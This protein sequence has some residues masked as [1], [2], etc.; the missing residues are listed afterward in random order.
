MLRKTVIILFTATLFIMGCAPPEPI[1]IYLIGD[2]IT[3]TKP[4]DE[5]PMVGWGQILPGYFDS[6][7]VNIHNHAKN[8]RSTKSF[9]SEGRW[10]TVKDS[11]QPG[12]WVLIQFGHNDEKEYDTTRYTDPDS[13]FPENLKKFVREARDLG[14]TPLLMTPVVRRKF[15]DSGEPVPTHGEYPAAVQGVAEKL[16]V[17]FID[18]RNRSWK[19]LESL[20]VHGSKKLWLLLEP[21]ESENWPDGLEDNSHLSEYGAH[22]VCQMIVQGI[23]GNDIPLTP[24]L[25]ENFP[26]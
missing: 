13:A 3:A 26:K 19:Q 6:S 18:I 21:G 17:Y 2:S 22:Q 20:G 16:D 7:L 15:D 11:L 14:A 10:T 23:R 1:E 24:Y 4:T 25:A 12:D 9:I 8:G 5:Y